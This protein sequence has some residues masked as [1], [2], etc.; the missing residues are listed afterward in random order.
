MFFSIISP[1]Y[2]GSISRFVIQC[3][4]DET[5]LKFGRMFKLMKHPYKCQRVFPLDFMVFILLFWP[6]QQEY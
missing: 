6:S 1:D 2:P 5:M 4:P 3:M